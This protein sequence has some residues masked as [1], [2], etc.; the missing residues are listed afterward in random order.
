MKL[1]INPYKRENNTKY[2]KVW[3]STDDHDHPASIPGPLIIRDR[4]QRAQNIW[5]EDESVNFANSII[6]DIVSGKIDS[7]SNYVGSNSLRFN[8]AEGIIIDKRDDH[9]IGYMRTGFVGYKEIPN[10]VRC[11]PGD[12]V[13][14][15]G[16]FNAYFSSNNT[17]Q[18]YYVDIDG[19]M[20]VGHVEDT[21]NV[22]D[23]LDTM[24]RG[25][26]VH[27]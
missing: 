8:K 20:K 22:N 12:D 25:Y 2:W 23:I 5:Y 10:Y 13:I 26:T 6:D 9:V 7:L 15:L 24:I 16:Y 21:E 4:E 1:D 17:W 19:M 11:Y 18:C 27:M 14:S 3:F